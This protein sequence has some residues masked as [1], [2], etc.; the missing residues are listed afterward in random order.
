MFSCSLTSGQV[1]SLLWLPLIPGYMVK[2]ATEERMLKKVF[3]EYEDYT[4]RVK[5][6]IPL[7]Y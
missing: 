5:M 6:I 7:V 4:R 3:P 2:A 1:R